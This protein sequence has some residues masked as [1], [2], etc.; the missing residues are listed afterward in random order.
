M[1]IPGLHELRRY[2]PAR[3]DLSSGRRRQ[4]RRSAR[5]RPWKGFHRHG[6]SCPLRLDPARIAT[7]A[8]ASRRTSGPG[9]CRR[10]RG[11]L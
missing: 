11:A 7:V 10:C 4:C 5:T 3:P 9:R 6:R 8:R 2:S 1:V